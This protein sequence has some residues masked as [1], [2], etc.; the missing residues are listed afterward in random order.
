MHECETNWYFHELP[1][2][3]REKKPVTFKAKI[4]KTNKSC[5]CFQRSLADTRAVLYS[6]APIHAMYFDD[7]DHK[8]RFTFL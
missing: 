3:Q 6:G 1:R 5:A 4:E 8:F 2:Q 7:V